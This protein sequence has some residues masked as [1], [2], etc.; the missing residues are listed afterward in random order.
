MTDLSYN[1]SMV[2]QRLEILYQI[3]EELERQGGG[4]GGQ[5]GTDDYT[6]LTNKPR[7]ND[8]TLVGNKSLTDLGIA[9]AADLNSKADKS[10]TYT[11]T[12]V[13]TALAAK[14]NAATT[15][16]KTETQSYV[17]GEI[18]G[19]ITGLDVS[20]KGASDGSKYI[21]LVGQTDGKLT[22]TAFTPALT[23]MANISKPPTTD[24]VNSAINNAK[25]AANS[26]TDTQVATKASV[27]DI[28][29][30]GSNTYIPDAADL[31]TYTQAG[32]YVRQF[33]S[34]L[35]DFSNLPMDGTTY[36]YQPFKLI[37]EYINSPNNI[38]Q[39]L[40]PTYS[41][42]GFFKRIR[43]FGANGTWQTWQWFGGTA[44]Q[45]TAG[46]QSLRPDASL[47]VEPNGEVD[48]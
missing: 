6:E 19:A 42:C 48:A 13:D 14:A 10:T 46:L 4:G 24:A 17:Q 39:T 3:V 18:T 28:Y 2:K 16:T 9:S 1:L 23:I 34:G 33:S 25:A 36:P 12:Q 26:Y 31:N 11:K 8:I 5:G 38:V 29:G 27:N 22:A 7:I 40:V 47:T 43:I 20:S 15:Y 45:P 32:V 44:V 37:V 21:G 41:N 35:A 30:M